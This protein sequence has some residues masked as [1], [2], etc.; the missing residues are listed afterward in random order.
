[1]V[2][3]YRI[4]KGLS[5]QAPQRNEWGAR[6]MKISPNHTEP[7]AQFYIFSPYQS[8]VALRGRR[9]KLADWQPTRCRILRKKKSSHQYISM[10]YGPNLTNKFA[11]PYV[12]QCSIYVLEHMFR[13]AIWL[14]RL[15][16]KRYSY[17]VRM[18]YIHTLRPMRRL[19][20]IR[21]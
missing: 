12:P 14:V 7:Y 15:I 18:S 13:I 11:V 4:L 20:L 16:H 5:N 19:L 9:Y 2:S 10:P 8:F 3:E 17:T 21:T 6:R 1:M